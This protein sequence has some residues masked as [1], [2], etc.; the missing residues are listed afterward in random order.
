MSAEAQ[1]E[2]NFGFQLHRHNRVVEAEPFYRRALE[3]DPDFKEAGRTWASR[4]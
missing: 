4:S 1:A 3:L 2:H